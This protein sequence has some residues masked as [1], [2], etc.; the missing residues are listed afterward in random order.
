MAGNYPDVP[1]W[2]MAWDRD[3][4][5]MYSLLDSGAVTQRSGA[6]AIALNNETNDSAISFGSSTAGY[7]VIIFPELRDLDG[8]FFSSD[9][10]SSNTGMSSVQVSAD[11]TNGIDGTWSAYMSGTLTDYG[12]SDKKARENIRTAT[13]L[14]IRAVRFRRTQGAQIGGSTSS[15][16]LFGEPAPGENPQRLEIWHPTLDQRI[17]PADLDWGDVPRNSTA[18]KSFRVKNMHPTLTANS[19]RVAQEILTDTVPSVVGQSTISKDGGGT[20]GAQQTIGN[21]A[22]EAISDVLLL[23][24]VTPANATLSLW[25]YRLFAD[26]TSWS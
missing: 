19:V 25:W 14:G 18:Q 6:E 23:R 5:Q 9:S 26:C 24:R 8:F 13:A 1:S 15:I 10:N 21:L 2:R 20:W 7:I 3:G 4:S 11:T 16:H 17:G 22:P 12:F